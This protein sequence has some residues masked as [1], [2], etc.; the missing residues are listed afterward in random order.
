MPLRELHALQA[1]V[2]CIDSQQD[3][4]GGLAP[5]SLHS[6]LAIGRQMRVLAPHRQEPVAQDRLSRSGGSCMPE[7]RLRN[8]RRLHDALVRRVPVLS[9]DPVAF[10]DEA[11]LVGLGDHAAQIF[12]RC[13]NA[14]PIQSVGKICERGAPVSA[15]FQPVRTRFVP[16][17]ARHRLA[18][19]RVPTRHVSVLFLLREPRCSMLLHLLPPDVEGRPLPPVLRP[20]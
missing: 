1:G 4:S 19:R 3:G 15:E 5:P 8:D 10:D 7:H 11:L 9:T 20:R 13:L 2:S 17:R 14:R 6:Q 18:D 16:Q 12:Q